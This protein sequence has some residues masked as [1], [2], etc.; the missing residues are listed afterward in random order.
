M[1]SKFLLLTLL[2]FGPSIC[3][4][5][6]YK[7]GEWDY[8]PGPNG[9]ANWG[10]VTGAAK[11]LGAKQSPIDINTAQTIEKDFS[12][13]VF[14][15]YNSNGRSGNARPTGMINTGKTVK[16][17]FEGHYL[18]KGGGLPSIYKLSHMQFH[19]G[20]HWVQGSEHKVDGQFFPAEFHLVH[21]DALQYPSYFDASTQPDGVAILGF[22]FSVGNHNGPW[23]A[24]LNRP[25]HKVKYVGKKFDYTQQPFKLEALL[26]MNRLDKFY[27]YRG[28]LTAPGCYESVTW[29]VFRHPIEVS[30]EQLAALRTMTKLAPSQA[31]DGVH[32]KEDLILNNCRPV[33]ESNWPQRKVY[34]SFNHTDV[35]STGGDRIGHIGKDY[36]GQ[37][38]GT[39]GKREQYRM[40]KEVKKVLIM[41]VKM[42]LQTITIVKIP[43]VP[44]LIT[45]PVVVAVTTRITMK[46]AVI[47]MMSGFILL[48]P[49]TAPRTTQVP[50]YTDH[51]TDGHWVK[52][53]L[54]L[55]FF[56]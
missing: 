29:T 1:E 45:T 53:Y 56:C 44:D 27:R 22:F 35:V 31:G 10:S 48:R 51:G 40:A 14:R 15:N 20:S 17:S 18:I 11:C 42:H 23:D 21:Y 16:I 47:T 54:L 9:P 43:P 55:A 26:P 19:W 4:A 49:I 25:L 46:A 24:I 8:G 34:Q 5:R 30:E 50:L 52:L 2:L 32:R 36:Y 13:F 12:P 6:E 28:S 41:V 39:I 7:Y 33:Q 37:V 3:L 38:Y